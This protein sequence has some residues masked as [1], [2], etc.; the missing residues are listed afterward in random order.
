MPKNRDQR[1]TDEIARL[2]QTVNED[3]RGAGDRLKIR[4][5]QHQL[6]NFGVIAVLVLLFIIFLFYLVKNTQ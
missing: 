2:Q 1:V 5:M 3:R 4:E 6:R